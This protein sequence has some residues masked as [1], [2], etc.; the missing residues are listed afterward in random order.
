M[1]FEK[2]QSEGIKGYPK[3]LFKQPKYHSEFICNTPMQKF[4]TQLTNQL[5]QDFPAWQV[6][7][8]LFSIDLQSPVKLLAVPIPVLLKVL[9]QF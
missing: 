1:T 9:Y 4:T 3:K 5:T 2:S 6:I 8:Q 7:V